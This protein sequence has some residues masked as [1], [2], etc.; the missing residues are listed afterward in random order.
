MCLDELIVYLIKEMRG[1]GSLGEGGGAPQP[2][3][4]VYFCSSYYTYWQIIMIIILII[5]IIIIILIIIMIIMII[6]IIIIMILIK[7]IGL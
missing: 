2:N 5:I 6:M 1:G 7:I 3:M 4:F